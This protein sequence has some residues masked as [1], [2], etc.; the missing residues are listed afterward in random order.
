MSQP[1]EL[2]TF[3]VELDCI[4]DTRLSLVSNYGD[5]AV[6]IA[7]QKGYLTRLTD[8]FEGID[9]EDYKTAYANRNN[10]ILKNAMMTPV[11]NMMREFITET[12]KTS[13]N[14]PF[15][16]TPR[17][18]I[19]AH[20]YRFTQDEE[21]VLLSTIAYKLD[22]ACDIS[23]IYKP[24]E[25]ITPDIV[26]N[27]YSIMVMYRYDLWGEYHAEQK[28]FEK[29]ICPEVTI[30]GPRLFFNGMPKK[31]DL[32]AITAQNKDPFTCLEE[33]FKPIVNLI[34]YP[35]S[36]FSININN[37]STEGFSFKPA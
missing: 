17:I 24:M 2:S 20:P 15:K 4:L 32:D 23:L 14:S 3:Y 37:G 28:H 19:N 8:T 29:V 10:A 12:I 34:T 35:V 22:S 6:E 9:P 16:L 36:Y 11:L 5:K 26:K 7:L 33:C 18:V 25:S 30:I 21:E 27:T 13:I 31:E 1:A